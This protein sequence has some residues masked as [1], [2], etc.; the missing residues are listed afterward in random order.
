MILPL[1]ACKR[2]LLPVAVFLLPFA[3]ELFEAG[4]QLFVIFYQL[5]VVAFFGSGL[6]GGHHGS[7][8]RQYPVPDHL[9]VLLQKPG[10]EGQLLFIGPQLRALL[11]GLQ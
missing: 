7:D 11:F 1:R 9:L 3:H 8:L 2:C 10:D 6:H 5:G 4:A